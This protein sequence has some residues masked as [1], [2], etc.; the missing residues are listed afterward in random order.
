MTTPVMLLA[1]VPALF[2]ALL[3]Q[4]LAPAERKSTE[5]SA[6]SVAFGISALTA[7]GQNHRFDPIQQHLPH[8]VHHW[9][10]VDLRFLLALN[11]QEKSFHMVVLM[12][13]LRDRNVP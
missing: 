9:K 13:G 2:Y 11:R 4:K 12:C 5:K 7:L 8:D 3:S 10:A 6:A 1:P